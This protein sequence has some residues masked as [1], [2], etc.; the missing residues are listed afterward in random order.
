MKN[1]TI[2]LVRHGE[3]DNPRNI[4]Y[5]S[6]IEM[7][8]S[9]KGRMQIKKLAF[10]ILK[11]G[12]IP[13][14]IYSSN[15]ERAVESATILAKV[16]GV[17]DIRKE[18]DLKDSF[19]PAIAGKPISFINDL[20]SR[21]LD[22]YNEKFLEHGNESREDVTNR[23]FRV[24]QK[25]IFQSQKCVVLVSHGDPIRFLLYKLENPESLLIPGMNILAKTDYLPKGHAWKLLLNDQGDL[26][27]KNS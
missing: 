18:S 12:I 8:L 6:N 7:K 15:L 21:G 2:F 14:K 11:S 17:L 19:V 27:S 1:T 5:G 16:L 13:S 22:E 25:A 9:D 20:H 4:I 26:L 3:I 23:M 24:Y 10:Q